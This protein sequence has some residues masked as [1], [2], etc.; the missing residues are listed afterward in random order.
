MKAITVPNGTQDA[1]VTVPQNGNVIDTL[2]AMG[3]SK[4]E[5]GQILPSLFL[6]L[7]RASNQDVLKARVAL[8]NPDINLFPFLS[9]IPLM[10]DLTLNDKVCLYAKFH[11]FDPGVKPNSYIRKLLLHPAIAARLR[12][13]KSPPY[14]LQEVQILER[15]AICNKEITEYMSKFIH[16]KMSFIVDNYGVAK[17]ELMESMQE[18]ALHNLRIN[19]PNWKAYG[20]MLAMAKSA[21]ANSGHNIIK[22]YAAEKR[23]KID[24]NN[25]AVEVS[26]D[27]MRE[28]AG[29]A[30][31]Y[32]A[33]V[34][35][36]VFERGMAELETRLSVDSILKATSMR[37]NV[38]HFL[39]LLAGRQ[40]DGF[41][42][43][44]GKNNADFADEV[45]FDK[46]MDKTC[47]YIGV[48]AE[49]ATKLL[50]SLRK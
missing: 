36:D 14:T 5:A 42:E 1:T 37:P 3:F 25:Q 8:I 44:L 11:D 17:E 45:S 47:A 7:F 16:R 9:R 34:F 32:T 13:F 39:R 19:F 20:D 48:T 29:D 46:L 26:L 41:T 6:Y 40:D 10:G 28:M 24:T 33:F 30:Y 38:N 22:F 43:Y 35:S 23:A 50:H 27:A 31:E 21:I 15:R 12:Q 2:T 4:R 49:R 18:R